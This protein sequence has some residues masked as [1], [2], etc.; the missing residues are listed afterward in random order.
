MS[1]I[2]ES[3]GLRPIINAWAPMTRF[4]GGIMAPEVVAAMAAATQ[5]CID[6]PE[7]QASGS[8]IIAEITGA[9]AGC[10]TSGASAALLGGTAAC[11]TGLDPAKMN[12]LPDTRAM[13][14]EV[15]VVRSQRNSYDHALR[16]V[17]VTLVEVGLSDR[18]AGSGVRDAEPWE[19]KD[20]ITDRTAAIFYVANPHSRPSLPAVTEVAREAGLPVLVDAAAELPPLANLRRF[21]AEGA[22]L[23]AF[24]GGKA[25]NGPQGSGFLCGRRDLVGAALL[26]QLDLDYVA[27]EWEPPRELIDRRNLP[28]LPRHGIARSC[29][30]GKEQ[31]VGALTALKLFAREGDQGRRDRLQAI[32]EKLAAALAGLPFVKAEIIADPDLTGMPVV[33]LRLDQTGAGIGGAELL[34]RLSTGSPRIEA[35]PWKAEE[36]RLI[37]SPACL[38]V[39]DA[40]LIGRRLGEIMRRG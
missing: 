12:R 26:Q 17:G 24:S 38:R 3:L 2:Y 29:K 8:R 4:G 33:E 28:G 10:V 5:H 23:V 36:G 39:G 15:I 25:I 22:D 21:L 35:N 30:T 20:A 37:L 1:D 9:E 34:R 16:A 19:I 18:Y 6:I 31:I 7:L 40:E 14:N 11:V 13:R 32:A 27:D